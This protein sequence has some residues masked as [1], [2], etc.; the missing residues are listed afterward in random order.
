MS[1]GQDKDVGIFEDESGNR[2][3][4]IREFDLNDM[5]PCDSKDIKSG[6]K[7]VIIGKPNTGKSTLIESI[8]YNKAHIFPICQIFSGTESA[9]HFYASK[10]PDSL[11]YD[12]LDVKALENF[13]KRQQIAMQYLPNP[14]ALCILDDCS[15]DASIIN[16][17]PF[18][19]YYKKGRHWRMLHILA[20]Q[21]SLD[22]KPGIRSCVDYAFL[23]ATSNKTDRKKL[24]E[25]FAA[26][27]I[28]TF[29][30]FCDIMDTITED[31]TALVINNM[32]TSNKLED[33]VFYYKADPTIIPKDFKICCNEAY[34]CNRERKDPNYIPKV[35]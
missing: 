35:L 8:M 29:Q 16:R 21:Y 2:T 20:L 30:D 10:C 27:C 6:A 22:I 12:D 28:P 4:Y 13:A 34:E 19:A 7:V 32:T 23:L 14:W 9:N 3:V 24:Y 25:N 31:R 11:I 1:D 26:G 33:R 17:A 5:H 18:P 15:D